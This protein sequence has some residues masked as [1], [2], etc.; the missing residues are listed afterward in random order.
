MPFGPGCWI[1]VFMVSFWFI[2]GASPWLALALMRCRISFLEKLS[3]SHG[4]TISA[5]AS[6]RQVNFSRPGMGCSPHVRFRGFNPGTSVRAGGASTGRWTGDWNHY[7]R[8]PS[9][10]GWLCQFGS[11]A[12]CSRELYWHALEPFLVEMEVGN[13]FRQHPLPVKLPAASARRA[14]TK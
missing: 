10:D 6:T 12:I 8:K 9:A 3:V 2:F 13:T 4:A 11:G 14:E 1:E 5:I 7:S